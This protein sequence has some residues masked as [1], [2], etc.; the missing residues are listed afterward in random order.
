MPDPPPQFTE[1][2]DIRTEPP[3]YMY[4]GPAVLWSQH[5]W[6]GYCG[7]LV[8]GWALSTHRERCKPS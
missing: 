6:C 5:R 7:A 3:G 4:A 8:N 1:V 2:P